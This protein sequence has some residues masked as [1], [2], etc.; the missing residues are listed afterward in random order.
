MKRCTLCGGKL[1]SQKR[2]TLCGLDNTK[3]DSMYRHMVNKNDCADEPLTHVHEEKAPKRQSVPVQKNSTYGTP[4]Y[5]NVS[6]PKKVNVPVKKVQSGEKKKSGCVT[7]IG[8][9]PFFIAIIGF[10]VNIAGDFI[11][12]FT[13]VIPEPDYIYEETDYDPYAWAI[14]E[15]PEVG[16]VFVTTLTPGVYEVG[17]HIPMGTYQIEMMPDAF[18]MIEVYD[19]WNEIYISEYLDAD[20]DKYSMEE[21]LLFEGA[22]LVV[23]PG[24]AVTLYTDNAQPESVQGIGTANSDSIS[25][26]G[27]LI[28]G[29]DFEPGAYN[30]IYKPKENADAFLEVV[31]Y[32]DE[33]EYGFYI[34]FDSYMGDET[35]YYV[36]LP[37]GARVVVDESYLDGVEYLHMVPSASTSVTDLESF[38]YAY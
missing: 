26:G 13:D 7:F 37:D 20:S 29:V 25:L 33:C 35:F 2:C 10:I 22:Y 38:Y 12:E 14:D 21:V 19:E 36:P 24:T 18:G 11:S 3:N 34:T 17:Y 32:T 4:S 31:V 16:D 8:L 23:H 1:D 27:E 30:I 9:I 15:M 6:A 5:K 28:A